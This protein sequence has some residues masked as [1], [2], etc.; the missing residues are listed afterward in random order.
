MALELTCQALPSNNAALLKAL[1]DDDF[2]SEFSFLVPALKFRNQEPFISCINESDEIKDLFDNFPD[3]D[4]YTFTF[5]RSY[6]GLSYI[7]NPESYTANGDDYSR[8]ETRILLGNETM[9][10]HA[11]GAKGYRARYSD[12]NFVKLSSE[13][14]NR[15]V[16]DDLAQNFDPVEMAKLELYA[17]QPD[18]TFQRYAKRLPPMREF[19]ERSASRGLLHSLH[20]GLAK[21]VDGTGE[22]ELVVKT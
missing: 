21:T 16:S 11:R 19:Y 15:L 18:D 13:Y 14:L 7:L 6:E 2:W 10:P 1:V 20:Q 5:G 22:G 3:I 4:D 8:L 12:P 17:C 9:P